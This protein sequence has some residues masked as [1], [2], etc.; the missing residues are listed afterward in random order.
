MK[1]FSR[2][3]RIWVGVLTWVVIFAS[4]MTPTLYAQTPTTD[5]IAFKLV[6]IGDTYEVYMTPDITPDAPSLTLTAQVTIRA[7]HGV[8]ANAFSVINLQST[9]AGT[10]WSLGSRINAPAEEPTIDYLS[11]GVAFPAND[12]GAFGWTANQ[13]IKV[14]TFQNGGPCLGP[15]ALFNNDTDPFIDPNSAGTNPGNQITVMGIDKL[16]ENA[17]IGNY[18]PDPVVGA[19]CAIPPTPT[20]TATATNTTVP[21]TATPTATATN[22]TVPSTATPTATATNTTV[23]STATPTATATNT[24][25]P[26]TATATKTSVP[27]S[28]TPTATMTKTSV[29]PSATP[30]AT[31]TS[32]TAPPTVTPLPTSSIGIEFAIAYNNGIYELFMRPNGTPNEPILTLTSQMT[33][34]VPHGVGA[35][36]FMIADLLSSVPGT[37]WSLT[38]R[39]DAPIEDRSSDYLSFV[40]SFTG[41]DYGVYDWVGGQEVKVFTFRNTGACLGITRLMENDT[42][43]FNQL[44][45]SMGTNPG[46]QI[47]V[48]T[49][50]RDNAYIG[51][52]GSAQVNC[53]DSGEKDQIGGII[54]NDSSADGIRQD[55]EARI[56]G[57]VVALHR[58]VGADNTIVLTMTTDANGNFQTPDS[59]RALQAANTQVA[60]ALLVE[61]GVY[62]LEFMA[63]SGLVPT[64]ANQGSNDAIDSD[65][66]RTG[67]E[68]KSLSGDITTGSN[69]VLHLRDAGFVAPASIT[70]TVYN[71]RDRDG[72]RE[73]GENPVPGS[74]IVVYDTAGNEI[75]RA[76]A[77]ADGVFTVD[78]LTPDQ[79]DIRITPPDGFEMLVANPVILVPLDAGGGLTKDVGIA[80][81]TTGVPTDPKAIDLVSFLVIP[82]EGS[83]LLRWETAA[84]ENTRGFY[85][86]LGTSSTFATS[87]RLTSNLVLSQ[88]SRGGV[89]EVEMPY[90]P[91]YDP[92][93]EELHFWLL[94]MELD[95][96]ENQYGPF[97]ILLPAMYLPLVMR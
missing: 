37:S 6:L 48:Y 40:V 18:G 83:I 12:R 33:I 47:D 89:Y 80:Q 91:I 50:N 59:S 49:I 5:G 57:A 70:L 62:Y 66:V 9:V 72:I 77:D 4:F 30:T 85:V 60:N 31:A 11:F 81:I 42:D 96:S 3:W 24:T 36:R 75:T 90:D 74:T 67:L 34:K 23:P 69:G 76:I 41:G 64:K 14:F 22:T 19:N 15:L 29:P 39:I 56:A 25:V 44:P 20:V 94:E 16:D 13:E 8:G 26:A 55:N 51:N 87:T 95:S 65:G 84:E 82:R 97:S 71:D 88:G 43:P 38:S 86:Y 2:K 21:S 1:G 32:T 58:R 61:P 92:P 68:L 52:Y 63:P 79:Y 17:Y 35:D 73:D 93:L 45:N 54:W 10:E 28:A 78:N 53:L 7:P 46:N 27:P